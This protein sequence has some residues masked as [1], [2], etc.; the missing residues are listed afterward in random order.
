MSIEKEILHTSRVVAVV[1]LSS[2]PNRQ[3]YRVANYLKENGYGII[4]VNPKAGGI[5]GEAC[6]PH[7][8]P[9]PEPADVVDILTEVPLMLFLVWLC[10]K[11]RGLFYQP[12]LQY[13][14]NMRSK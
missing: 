8:S 10:R 5:L 7:L 12:Q 14:E 11:T 2:K 6:H 3:R 9:I 4:P 13:T 1:G